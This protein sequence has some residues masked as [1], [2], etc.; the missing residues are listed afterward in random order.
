MT[1]EWSV[2][3]DGDADRM[4]VLSTLSALIGPIGAALDHHQ[5]M[6]VLKRVSLDH[7]LPG[8]DDWK[9]RLQSEWNEPAL[10]SQNIPIQGSVPECL[11]VA[12]ELLSIRI[13]EGTMNRIPVQI[14]CEWFAMF[15]DVIEAKTGV[16]ERF[17]ELATC[18]STH[19]LSLGLQVSIESIAGSPGV[20]PGERYRLRIA[21]DPS[22]Y[23]EWLHV[24]VLQQTESGRWVP[25]YP[26]LYDHRVS[27]VIPGVDLLVPDLVCAYD[28][29]AP[30]RATS[31]P[32][33]VIAS[34]DSLNWP[35]TYQPGVTSHL[36]REGEREAS[37]SR[38]LELQL[39][40]L[41]TALH[42]VRHCPGYISLADATLSV[43]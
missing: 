26:N 33:R 40:T 27:F 42:L 13:R 14:E 1:S 24:F 2:F 28:L 11:V 5:L 6:K 32:T 31:C 10:Q 34:R 16:H 21:A 29:I 41:D 4:R 17:K 25:L 12:F 35:V 8:M 3:Q 7:G 39:K 15:E 23:D 18:E 20:K 30:E 37:Y 9:L 19:E 43:G 36:G 38:H 22:V